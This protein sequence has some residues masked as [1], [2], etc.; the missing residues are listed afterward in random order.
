MRHII[1]WVILNSI[2]LLSERFSTLSNDIK[3]L[4]LRFD[5]ALNLRLDFLSKYE[6]SVVL[7]S[8]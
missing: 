5:S 6:L 8:N 4:K 2:K 3:K 1:I 7:S